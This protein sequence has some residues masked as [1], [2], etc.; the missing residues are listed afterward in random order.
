[1]AS[2]TL[3]L[4]VERPATAGKGHGT[5][6]LGPSDSSDSGS[7][8]H[9]AGDDGGAAGGPVTSTGRAI[10]DANIDSDTDS[11][12]TGEVMAAGRDLEVE[13]SADIGVDRV[14][15]ADEAGLG[16][17]L[18]QAE[19]A[20]L[21]ITDEEIDEEIRAGRADQLAQ[22]E[23]GA[24]GAADDTPEDASEAIAGGV[25]EDE[26]MDQLRSG[27]SSEADAEAGADADEGDAR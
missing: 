21:G 16:T 25:G 26:L 20:Q 18:D 4:P 6:A 5:S 7:D 3:D 23:A 17:G 8:L 14:I 9:G 12:G 1:M 13:E 27:A 10:G 24:A 19:E 22:R 2:S 15:S 11:H